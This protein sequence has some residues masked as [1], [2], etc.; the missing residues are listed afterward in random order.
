MAVK[1]FFTLDLPESVLKINGATM[2]LERADAESLCKDLQEALGLGTPAGAE[3]A[4]QAAL[5][6]LSEGMATV[7][8]TDH[9][10]DTGRVLTPE[11][12]LASQQAQ[13][14]APAPTY[15]RN[16]GSGIGNG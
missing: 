16:P 7:D 1:T 12:Y 6:A 5:A 4:I 14:A 10:G 3:E 15:R 11:Q 9:T 8:G 2:T 13:A